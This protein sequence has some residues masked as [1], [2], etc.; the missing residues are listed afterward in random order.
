MLQMSHANHQAILIATRS[1]TSIQKA[2]VEKY[3]FLKQKP[4]AFTLQ[5][6]LI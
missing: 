5:N 6:F 4:L 2:D 1:V 3:Q